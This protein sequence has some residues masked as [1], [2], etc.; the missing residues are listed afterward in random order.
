MNIILISNKS[1]QAKNIVLTNTHF[2]LA[3]S[4]LVIV[5][6]ILAMGMNYLTLHYGD[7][8]N[9]RISGLFVVSPQQD[10][11][12][13]AHHAHLHDNL[14]AMAVKLVV[15]VDGHGEFDGDKEKS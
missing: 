10:G 6:I 7:K 14:D 2:V 13:D 5:T 8:I 9:D 11:E 15:I 4:S 3:A 1:A 12:F